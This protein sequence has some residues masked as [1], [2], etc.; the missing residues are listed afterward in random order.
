VK[1]ILFPEYMIMNHDIIRLMRI[2]RS[3]RRA[4][5]LLGIFAVAAFLLGC[6]RSPEQLVEVSGEISN[7]PADVIKL[8]FQ[9][10]Q[11]TMEDRDVLLIPGD[12]NSFEVSF[13][14]DRPT[15]A[16]LMAGPIGTPVFLEPEYRLRLYFDGENM[17][18]SL[19]F[20]G[21]GS[22][23][24]NFLAQYTLEVASG[25]G[26]RFLFGQ[27]A[28][29]GPEAF[30]E[31][32]DSITDQQLA[33][34]DGYTQGHELSA[35]FVDYFQ[36]E[37]SYFRFNTLLFYP[38][39][40]QMVN[41]LEELPGLPADYYQFLEEAT[42]FAD[43]KM[44]SGEY[45]GFA[46]RYL[47]HYLSTEL[48]LSAEEANRSILYKLAGT[49]LDGKT[50]D[51]IRARLVYKALLENRF[52][53]ASALFHDFMQ[54]GGYA[55]INIR[56]EA[57]FREVE[58]TAPGRPAPDFTLTDMGGAD[59]SV[60]DYRGRVVFLTFW[61][62][63]SLRC[64]QDIAFLR[65]FQREMQHVHDLVFLSVAVDGD[66]HSWLDAVALH[67]FRGEHVHVD[68]LRHEVPDSYRVR[69]VP[70]Y[71]LIG[72]DGNFL[73]NRLPEPSEPEFRELILET[74]NP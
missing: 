68:G 33:Y 34:L 13:H 6:G 55:P 37:V 21:P 47:L 30:R 73:E 54:G 49:L 2:S 25:L 18:E 71:F 67:Q 65:E 29:L 36:T 58:T 61:A 40:H 45:N 56:L 31:L 16:T 1:N 57:L 5:S 26:R 11:M 51:L 50:R 12:D 27:M 39:T 24:N 43:Y 48:D 17:R 23:E 8:V 74:L 41:Q 70:T 44:V 7:P 42:R 32:M 60:S 52:D 38:M 3:G 53:E 28:Q 10:N 15:P 4:F 63:Y 62:G 46:E 72:R 59:I 22:N 66:E 19:R 69:Q 35:A 20:Q 9:D 14:I 64:I